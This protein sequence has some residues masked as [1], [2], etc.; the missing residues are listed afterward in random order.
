MRIPNLLIFYRSHVHTQTHKT[1]AHPQFP[2]RFFCAP[3]FS[4]HMEFTYCLSCIFPLSCKR[5][6]GGAFGGWILNLHSGRTVGAVEVALFLWGGF[7][8]AWY[9][10]CGSD[11]SVA[12]AFSCSAHEVSHSTCLNLKAGIWMQTEF[13]F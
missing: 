3:P 7:L 5:C 11:R 2:R 6:F 8:H 1:A 13:E 12:V 4:L 10:T 9:C